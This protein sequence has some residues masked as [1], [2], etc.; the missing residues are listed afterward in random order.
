MA[1]FGELIDIQLNQFAAHLTQSN[2]V[3]DKLLA[4]D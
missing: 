1:Q 4:A 3:I 2:E